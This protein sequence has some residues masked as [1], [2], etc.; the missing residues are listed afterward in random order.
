MPAPEAV[1]EQRARL[2]AEAYDRLA[3]GQPDAA[4]RTADAMLARAPD[5]VDARVLRGAALKAA[6][7]YPE[8]IAAFRAALA[9]DPARPA[10]PM[11]VTQ[12]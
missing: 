3:A 6:G 9:R 2:L 11:V 8:A 4:L 7:R 1:R 12:V 5:D 10:V